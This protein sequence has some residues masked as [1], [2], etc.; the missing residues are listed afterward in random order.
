MCDS[1]IYAL[2]TNDEQEEANDRSKQERLDSFKAARKEELDNVKLAQDL[3]L[4]AAN[5]LKIAWWF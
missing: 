2:F 5:P 1:D 3:L 4:N